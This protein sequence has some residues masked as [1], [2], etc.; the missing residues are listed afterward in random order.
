[1]SSLPRI[2]SPVTDSAPVT[3][4]DRMP[5]GRGRSG[6]VY[7][8]TGTSGTVAVKV[9]RPDR[10][11]QFVLTAMT[12]APNPYRWHSGAA[13][14]AVLRRRVLRTLVAY[15]FGDRLRVPSS[16]GPRWNADERAFEFEAEFIQ[17]GH[18][19]L[20]RG[21][22]DERDR[23]DSLVNDTMRPLQQHLLEAGCVGLVWQAGL[24]NPVA[25]G[26]FM[27]ERR[28][29]GAAGW[30]WID[31]E[32]GIPP[33][34][35]LNPL[36]LLRFY[37][38]E[39]L[40]RR[41]LLFDDIDVPVLRRYIA[42]RRDALADAVGSQVLERLELD[43][44]ELERAQQRW[45]SMTRRDRSLGHAKALGW[46]DERQADYYERRPIRWMGRQ[47]IWAV[48]ATG[49]LLQNAASA[50]RAWISRAGWRA[51]LRAGWRFVSSASYRSRAS[52]RYIH[53]RLFSWHARQF[54][55]NP[56]LRTLRRGL[57]NE[58]AARDISDFGV[59][60]AIKPPVSA[61]QYWVLPALFLVGLIDAL[62]LAVGVTF[63][64]SACRTIY[65]SGRVLDCLRRGT[66][67]PWTALAV[68]VIPLGGIAAFPL[69]LARSAGA[70]D[71]GLARF[72]VCDTFASIG[73]AIPVWGGRD[74]LVEHAFNRVGRLLVAGRVAASLQGRTAF[75][76]AT[77]LSATVA[78]PQNPKRR[79]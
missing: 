64:E 39:M 15:W 35:P 51:Y 16:H 3:A 17:G 72:I 70:G 32:S 28:A 61:I 20:L 19:P 21:D 48:Q 4:G 25:G 63:A 47:T 44:G 2:G 26:N 22:A 65:T 18:L 29:S 58:N 55:D 33:V 67:A 59:H 78:H 34:L 69:Q 31:L 71:Q 30:V 38:P 8:T 68:G 12:G 52:R 42:G 73:R 79:R 5:I 7:R 57:R 9:L 53:Q 49:R 54:L 46:I 10:L 66:S 77:P 76:T 74:S 45:K 60:L 14:A 56:E 1:M 37:L 36:A 6:I 43:V 13:S 41:R 40:R 23:M 75:G 24:G 11:M 62:T 27:V 50:V